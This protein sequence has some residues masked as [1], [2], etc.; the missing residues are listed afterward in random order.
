[1]TEIEYLMAVRQ[2][3]GIGT[4][5]LID[6][7]SESE[8]GEL[9]RACKQA[10]AIV[11]PKRGQHIMSGCHSGQGERSRAHTRIIKVVTDLTG[12][13]GISYV[14]EMQIQVQGRQKPQ[15]IDVVIN[16]V[17][18]NVR[19]WVDVT[20]INE[21]GKT[22]QETAPVGTS[23]AVHACNTRISTKTGVHHDEADAQNATLMPFVVGSHGAFYPLDTSHV[24]I[25]RRARP[26]ADSQG[27]LRQ[28]GAAEPARRKSDAGCR[29]GDDPEHRQ[30]GG[31]GRDRRL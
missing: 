27:H 15:R 5:G 8:T 16:D 28:Q 4:D 21:M 19:Y 11:E 26:R 6:R 7:P 12:Q 23:P 3:L 17:D 18:N 29:G 20:K 14:K 2:Q 24:N 10:S 22:N 30:P 13:A 25:Q 31:V 9:C 1:M